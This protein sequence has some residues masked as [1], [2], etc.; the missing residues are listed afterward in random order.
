MRELGWL[1]GRWSWA[2]RDR[3]PRRTQWRERG[4]ESEG[5]EGRTTGRGSRAGRSN[6]SEESRPP[7]GAIGRD[8]AQASSS[9]GGR[10][11]WAKARALNE[12][13]DGRT[14]RDH[15]GPP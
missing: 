14:P 3:T 15:G 11:P 10:T 8:R 1:R 9:R 7:E 13:G 5:R 6:S 4:H 12:V 2:E